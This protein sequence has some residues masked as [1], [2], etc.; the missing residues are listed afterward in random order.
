MV[1]EIIWSPLAIQ[2]YDNIIEYIFNKFGEVAVKRFVGRVDDKIK[3]IASRPTMFRVT[4]KR[5]NTYI[6]SIH[7]KTTL[8][9]RYYPSKNQV[10]LVVF[11]GMQDPTR[12]PG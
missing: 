1:K 7:K 8:T 12:R 5:S 3:L 10:E 9:Y 4:G 2:T 6:T 11:W